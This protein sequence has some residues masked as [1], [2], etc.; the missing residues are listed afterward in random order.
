MLEDELCGPPAVD[1]GEMAFAI[2]LFVAAAKGR[3]APP[4]KNHSGFS[5]QERPALPDDPLLAGARE[6]LKE[7]TDRPS[8][9]VPLICA[10]SVLWHHYDQDAR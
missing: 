9:E 7:E 2:A 4:R 5:I 10:V 6:I 1:T 8:D 3:I